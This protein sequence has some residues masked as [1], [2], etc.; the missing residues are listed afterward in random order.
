MEVCSLKWKGNP[1]NKKQLL[2]V[3]LLGISFG[4]LIASEESQLPPVQAT[5][6]IAFDKAFNTVFP[7]GLDQSFCETFKTNNN[8]MIDSLKK[9]DV[10]IATDQTFMNTLKTT[11]TSTLDGFVKNHL[12]PKVLLLT[13]YVSTS[14][15]DT[16]LIRNFMHSAIAAKFLTE[17][18]IERDT[19]AKL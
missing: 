3:T 17:E 1:M 6:T 8:I 16:L 2:L 19:Q 4:G 15:A 10:E 12:L 14:P 9:L 5:Y 7:N 11:S 18:L 13:V